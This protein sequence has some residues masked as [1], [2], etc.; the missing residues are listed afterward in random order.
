MGGIKT[1]VL[2]DA[3]ASQAIFPLSAAAAHE[4]AIARMGYV[5]AEIARTEAFVRLVTK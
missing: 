2:E 4:A 1:I 3:C 5:F